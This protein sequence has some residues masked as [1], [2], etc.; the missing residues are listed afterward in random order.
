MR[1]QQVGS[2]KLAELEVC[3]QKYGLMAFFPKSLVSSWCSLKTLDWEPC[4]FQAQLP[5]AAPPQMCLKGKPCSHLE[6]RFDGQDLG[7]KGGFLLITH[8]LNGQI[9]CVVCFYGALKKEWSSWFIEVL[10][11]SLPETSCCKYIARSLQVPFSSTGT[12]GEELVKSVKSTQKINTGS[13]RARDSCPF[14]R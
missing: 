13:D 7:P 14:L 8:V 4:H 9:V 11:T 2:P 5:P 3:S 10:F 6:A 12:K 1:N